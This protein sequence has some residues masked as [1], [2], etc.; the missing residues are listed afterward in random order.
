[1]VAMTMTVCHNSLMGSGELLS[2]LTVEDIEWD[3]SARCLLT[4]HRGRFTI[5]CPQENR[6]RDIAS[7]LQIITARFQLVSVGRGL[8]MVRRPALSDKF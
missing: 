8:H 1:M 5:G 3:L 6:V 4:L 7:D 2:G